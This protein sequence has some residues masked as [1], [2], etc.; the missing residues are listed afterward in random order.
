MLCAGHAIG[1]MI[2]AAGLAALVQL[3]AISP[4][5]SALADK[6]SR[7][8]SRMVS[9][10]MA[11]LRCRRISLIFPTPIPT[12][13]KAAGCGSASAADL[14]VSIR[15]TQDSGT[16]RK[17]IIGNVL[18]SLMTRSQ[19]EPYSLYPLI[20]Q[21]VE[22]DDAREHV[23]FHLDPRARFLRQDAHP[24]VGRPIFLRIAQVERSAEP[25]RDFRFSE[26]R[27]RARRPYGAFRSDWREGSRSAAH[28]RRHA[29]S[30]EEGDQ[31]GAL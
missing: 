28:S 20:A 24:C 13:R 23:T 12:R 27:R 4:P 3:T 1:R 10:S 7:L 22:I 21:S 14:Q 5:V 11:N 6:P 19:D 31:C 26:I 8:P 25:S 16:R 17:L 15:S 29:G 9:R 30:V 2:G 18:Q